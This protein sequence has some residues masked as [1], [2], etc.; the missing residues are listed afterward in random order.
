MWYVVVTTVIVN[1]RNDASTDSTHPR[2]KMHSLPPRRFAAASFALCALATL[3]L[4][5]TPVHAAEFDK[6][7]GAYSG[8]AQVDGG[9][10]RDMSVRIGRAKGGFE[11]QWKSISYKPDGRIK[12]KEYVV[13][14]QAT[15]RAEIF[16]STMGVDLFGNAVP[17]DPM[18]G[19]PYVWGRI[20]GDTLTVFSLLIDEGGGYEM[21]Q[22]NRTL[23]DGGLSLEYLRIR[24]GEKLKTINAFLK[25]N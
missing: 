13:G 9:T 19:D 17:L 25:R 15:Q 5:T 20:I 10:R 12:E 18:K 3:S 21:Q 2:R 4:S 8:S 16:A 23:A 6:F 14:F 1:N 11:V 24:N 7:I 22:Y